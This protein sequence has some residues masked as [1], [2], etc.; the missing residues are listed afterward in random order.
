MRAWSDGSGFRRWR[1]S[2]AMACLVCPDTDL[3]HLALYAIAFI[4]GW[5]LSDLVK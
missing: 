3:R 4:I 5:I 1:G 2:E